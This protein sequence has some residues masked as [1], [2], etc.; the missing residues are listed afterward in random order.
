MLVGAIKSTG[1]AINIRVLGFRPKAVIGHVGGVSFHWQKGMA[2]ASAYKRTAAG[3]GSLVV[4]N[5]I[6]P[7]SD[8]FTIGTDADINPATPTDISYMVIA[9]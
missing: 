4:V 7:L 8:G 9:E 5:G 2:D 1:G 6:T 3:V